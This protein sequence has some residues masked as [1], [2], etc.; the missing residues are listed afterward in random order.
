MKK[1]CLI[2]ASDIGY[3][4]PGIVY[5]TLIT[6]LMN[7]YDITLIS[8]NDKVDI[9]VNSL[10]VVSS[11]IEHNRLEEIFFTFLGINILDYIWLKR[12]IKIVNEDQIENQDL[13]ISF[14]SFHNYRSILLG[15]YLA[16]RFNKKWIIY[17]VDAIP[18]PLGWVSNKV[19]YNRLKCYI[20]KYISRADAFFSS[21]HQMLEYQK[22]SFIKGNRLTGVVYT[23]ISNVY[24]KI[25]SSDEDDLILLY[26]GGLYGPRK[27]EALLDGFRLLLID[28]PK[29][30]M[31][32]VGK[33]KQNFFNAYEDLIA[34]GNIEIHSYTND[35]N[36]FYSKSTILI[37]VNAYFDN[38]VFLSSKIVNYLAIKRPIL[39]IT[40]ENSPSRNIFIND[41][42]IFHCKHD[43]VEI[44]N[45]LKLILSQEFKDWKYRDEYVSDFKVEKVVSDF[46][47][48][49][50]V[51]TG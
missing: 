40:G 1:K 42:S 3:S 21:N 51:V 23:P 25:F 15:D 22:K 24:E 17:S 43:K 6:H 34:S 11:G 49:I 37:D 13:I 27:K 9:P 2:I 41:P 18:A 19:Y 16:A 12:Q 4:A 39:S 14:A 31:C 38:D 10:P 8:L 48:K 30:K 46:V 50:K 33:Y 29:A 7:E 36:K 20:S 45:K 5:K 35:L 44:Y 32:F 28:Y 47:K 26:T